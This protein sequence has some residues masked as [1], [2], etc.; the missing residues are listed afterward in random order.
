MP[1]KALKVTKM[2]Q[3]SLSDNFLPA[4]VILLASLIFFNIISKSDFLCKQKM[5]R[6]FP[7]HLCYFYKKFLSVKWVEL[8]IFILGFYFLCF[9]YKHNAALFAFCNAAE[10]FKGLV[11]VTG[12]HNSPFHIC[13]VFSP[14][15]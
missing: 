2:P 9:H 11:C 12:C 13:K 15:F 10:V 4:T 1:F 8:L 5:R 14:D 3:K 7:S 6:N